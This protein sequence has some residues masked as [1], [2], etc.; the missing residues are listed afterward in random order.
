M[1][2]IFV[3]FLY[4]LKESLLFLQFIIWHMQPLLATDLE[5]TLSYF[6]FLNFAPVQTY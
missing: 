2:F 6:C 3:L 1:S 5:T 4:R